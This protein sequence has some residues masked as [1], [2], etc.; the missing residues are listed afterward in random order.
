MDLTSPA[1]ICGIANH[2]RRFFNHPNRQTIRYQSFITPEN[3]LNLVQFQWFH[4]ALAILDLSKMRT[5][6]QTKFKIEMHGFEEANGKEFEFFARFL[7][8]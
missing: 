8:R 6:W 1:A 5:A 2:F 4:I 3:G 7:R